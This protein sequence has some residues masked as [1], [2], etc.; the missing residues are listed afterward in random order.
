MGSVVVVPSPEDQTRH[1]LVEETEPHK[2]GLLNLPGGGK[3]IGQTVIECGK[4]ETVEESGL[5]V[6]V[7]GILG[8]YEY[9][10]ENK[11]VI[12]LSAF[13]IGGEL[14]PTEEHPWQGFVDDDEIYRL[15]ADGRLRSPERI[16]DAISRQN[17]GR[18]M[19]LGILSVFADDA[20][21]S[22][23]GLHLPL[24]ELELVS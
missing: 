19:N 2:K 9:E 1:L 7:D 21:P 20:V 18:I 13:V 5:E 4:D 11:L 23:G 12:A 15:G 24:Q 22:T 17:E 3:K 8:I 6:E 14:R 16:I 10:E